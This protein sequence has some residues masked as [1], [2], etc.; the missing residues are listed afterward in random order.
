MLSEKADGK[1]G[2][3]LGTGITWSDFDNM[4]TPMQ[5]IIFRF[6][7][8]IARVINKQYQ[9]GNDYFSEYKEQEKFYK[10]KAEFL[11]GERFIWHDGTSTIRTGL[12]ACSWR[13][14]NAKSWYE[15]MME[16]KPIL[17]DLS[18]MNEDL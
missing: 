3:Y 18:I 10:E 12:P 5:M 9:K 14:L 15:I 4:P 16:K 8:N 1:M 13:Q 6:E 11:R 2:K 7:L 17:A